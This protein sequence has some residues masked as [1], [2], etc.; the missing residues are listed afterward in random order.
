[1]NRFWTRRWPVALVV[2]AATLLGISGCAGSSRPTS[3][4]G[5]AIAEEKLYASDL[6]QLQVLNITDGE[7][8]WAFPKDP[9]A[10]NRGAFYATPA[11]DGRYVMVTSHKA[12]T[13]FLSQTE[14]VVWAL[15]YDT[16]EL[17]WH[18]DGASGQYIEG[19]ALSEGLFV[20]G[21]SDGNVY[22]L[23]VESGDLKWV[24]ETGHRVWAT[25]LIVSDTVYIGSMDHHLYALSLSDGEVRWDF[26]A[27]GAFGSQ[28]MLR[29]D[30]LYVGAF[31]DYLYAVDAHTGTER[32][33]FA[34]ENWFWGSP[35]VYEDT[36]YAVDVNG[37]VYAVNRNTGEEI[38]HQPLDTPV[39]AGLA[40]AEDGSKLFV[41]SQEG[42]LYAL[43]TADGFV[44]WST[45]SDGEILSPPVVN[46]ATVYEALIYGSQRIRARHV[47]NGR[48]IWAYPPIEE[49]D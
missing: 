21:N 12:S 42:M 45:E 13:G 33:R 7:P 5:M 28:P 23:D 19:G 26:Q 10:D 14:D 25:P 6:E 11:V 36:V 35:A 15:D 2:L 9:K 4:T 43:E 49:E 32:W 41:G 20:A 29:D 18:F 17:L 8:A 1:M 31:D 16:G 38:W 37:N 39:R 44:L 34:G 40:M 24:F 22:A 30:T 27:Q 48:E 3:W 47:D 46:E